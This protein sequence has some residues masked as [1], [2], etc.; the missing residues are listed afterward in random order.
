MSDSTQDF[1][2]LLE[3]ATA[4]DT[5]EFDGELQDF[6]D[7]FIWWDDGDGV[8]E[9]AGDDA[10]LGGVIFDGTLAQLMCCLSGDGY[11]V[12]QLE[13]C[14][15]F[16]LGIMWELPGYDVTPNVNQCMSDEVSGTITFICEAV[17]VS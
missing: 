2:R 11:Y 14:T 1:T 9:P 5:T 13:E 3:R 7:I 8:Y 17:H 10:G 6:L 15:T 12:G 16:Y 4:G